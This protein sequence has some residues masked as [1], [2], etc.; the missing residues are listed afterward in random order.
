M[1]QRMTVAL[2]NIFPSA[3]IKVLTDFEAALA[4]AG[5]GPAIVLVAEP[6]SPASAPNPQGE[7]HRA[8]AYGPASSAEGSP[9]NIGRPAT[10]APLQARKKPGTDPPP[11]LT[12][13]QADCWQAKIGG[14]IARSFFFDAQLDAAF[15]QLCPS[16]RIG[17]LRISP[18]E[19]AAL[20][21]KY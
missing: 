20:A 21:A 6:G 2:Q 15:N 1:K 9:Y 16:A 17:T 11:R 13:K 19:A 4:A 3:A 18:A 8:G 5:E 7:I 12:L 14:T 10:P